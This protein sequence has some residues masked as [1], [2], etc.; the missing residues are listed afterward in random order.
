MDFSSFDSLSIGIIAID[1][2]GRVSYSNQVYAE[3]LGYTKREELL[4]RHIKE[5]MPH[6]KLDEVASTGVMQ[7]GVWQRT[8]HGFL[9]GNRIPIIEEGRC[10]GAF[11]E[12]ILHN[13]EELDDLSDKLVD[14]EE[15]IKYL[16]KK[17]VSNESDKSPQFIFQSY[18]MREIFSTVRKVAPLETTVLITGE[19]GCG[20]EI[21]AETLHQYSGRTDKPLIKVNCAAIPMELLESEFFGYEKGAFTGANQA[22]KIGK[23]ELADKGVLFLDEISSM[24]LAMQSKLLRVLQDKEIERLGGNTRKAVDVKIIAATNEN[25]EDLVAQNKFRQDLFYRLNVINLRVPPLRER[26]EDILLL[27]NHFLQRYFSRF[28]KEFIPLSLGAAKMLQ[29]YRWH[30]NVRELKNTMERLAIMCEGPRI[31]IT[32]MLQFTAIRN[33]TC[34]KASL[35]Q[36]LDSVERSIILDSLRRNE[37]SKST[38]AQELGLNRSTLYSKIEKYNM[39]AYAD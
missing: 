36:Q 4:G 30:G 23:F 20:K 9:F 29:N 28:N 17:L 34:K 1:T 31:T 33:H 15:Q 27:A 16:T 25:L 26:P 2:T 5:V 8:D 12:L 37:G 13:I 21:I 19:T 38:T 39:Y 6:T 35:K 22:G 24:P 7:K 18:S 10:T 11:A 14:M 3:F 32:D